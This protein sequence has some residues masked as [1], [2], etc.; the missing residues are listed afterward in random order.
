MTTPDQGGASGES[1]EQSFTFADKRRID[2][3]TGEVREPQ[4]Q[5]AEESAAERAA[6]DGNAAAAAEAAEESAASAPTDGA[7]ADAT[8]GQGSDATAG[9]AEAP[10]AD[11]AAK[12]LDDLQRLNAE[13][14]AYRRRSE[15]DQAKAKEAGSA[16]L[17]EALIPVLDEVKLA[18]DAGDVTGP[19]ETHVN[20]LLE[21]LSK[22]GVEQY[23]AVG[24][25]FDPA[26]HEAL[27][28]QPNGAV[29]EPTVFLVMQP[30]YKLGERVIRAARVGVHLPEE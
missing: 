2:P 11:E 6:A 21:A 28:Q 16:A 15:R 14:A 13:Y 24:D 26:L 7:S 17:V 20:K 4:E 23:G 3:E 27:M 8:A 22:V 29:E 5:T 1:Q 9:T 30:G 12:Y 19:F 10:V 18:A 25:E